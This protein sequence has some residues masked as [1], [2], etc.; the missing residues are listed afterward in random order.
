MQIVKIVL[1]KLPPRYQI[2]VCKEK[3]FKETKN[4]TNSFIITSHIYLVWYIGDTKKY[5]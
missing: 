5:V 3:Q 2:N 1:P 4:S